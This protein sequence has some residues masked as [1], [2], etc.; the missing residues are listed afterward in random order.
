MQYYFGENRRYHL[1][2]TKVTIS[3]GYDEFV[4]YTI[5]GAEIKDKRCYTSRFYNI[6]EG[7]GVTTKVL[8]IGYLWLFKSFRPSI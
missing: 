3:D 2:C 1:V 8:D 4:C 7:K 5:P 6:E